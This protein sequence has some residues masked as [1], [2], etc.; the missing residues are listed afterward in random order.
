MSYPTRSLVAPRFLGNLTADMRE[1]D[2][3][4]GEA[5]LDSAVTYDGFESERN[6]RKTLRDGNGQMARRDLYFAG[7]D[8]EKTVV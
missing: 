6:E 3:E 5:E 7:R 2:D 1:E 8:T 4:E